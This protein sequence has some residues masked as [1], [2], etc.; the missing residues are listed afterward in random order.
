MNVLQVSHS[1]TNLLHVQLT[2]SLPLDANVYGLGE[3]LASSGFRRNVA[4][5]GGSI[6]TM[7]AR[8]A[9][10]PIDENM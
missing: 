9:G 3:V 10:D 5:N 4:S 8:N 2:S 1:L 6:Q 7:W